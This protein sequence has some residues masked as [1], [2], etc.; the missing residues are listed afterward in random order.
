MQI[1]SV[2]FTSR[3]SNISIAQSPSKITK[4]IFE[5]RYLYFHF[6]LLTE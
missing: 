4:Y 6:C 5:N 3:P 2:L 1:E